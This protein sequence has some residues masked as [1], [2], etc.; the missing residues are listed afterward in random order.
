M[1]PNILCNMCDA[2]SIMSLTGGVHHRGTNYELPKIT[3][4]TC[5]G[6][7]INYPL[8]LMQPLTTANFVI[9]AYKITNP[10]L[11]TFHSK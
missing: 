9:G 8:H 6:N 2:Y 5:A 11:H 7:T 3:E 1:F 10:F 4:D